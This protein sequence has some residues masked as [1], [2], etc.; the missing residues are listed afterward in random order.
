MT[1]DDIEPGGP[2][3]EC[4][5]AANI[6]WPAF[7]DAFNLIDPLAAIEGCASILLTVAAMNPQLRDST[8]R[9]LTAFIQKLDQIAGLAPEGRVN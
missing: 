3:Y 5:R 4:Y 2:G 6:I 1:G 9:L 7:A 8:R